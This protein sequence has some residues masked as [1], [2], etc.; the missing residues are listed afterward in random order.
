MSMRAAMRSTSAPTQEGTFGEGRGTNLDRNSDLHKRM[1]YTR[2]ED[3]LTSDRVPQQ[4]TAHMHFSARTPA[5]CTLKSTALKQSRSAATH[6]SHALCC[7]DFCSCILYSTAR[8]PMPR[9]I[10]CMPVAKPPRYLEF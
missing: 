7:K 1:S 6:G 4:H 5:S 3:M 2:Y 8:D 9:C 10:C